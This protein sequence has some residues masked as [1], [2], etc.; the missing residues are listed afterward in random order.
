[1]FVRDT[2]VAGSNPVASTEIK[3]TVLVKSSVFSYYIITTN[4]VIFGNTGRI[5]K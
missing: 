2:E 5:T 4:A 1:M 3:N